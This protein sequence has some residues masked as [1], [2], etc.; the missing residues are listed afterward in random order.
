MIIK[1]KPVSQFPDF[2]TI[3]DELT[4]EFG[5]DLIDLLSNMIRNVY[6]DIVNLEKAAERVT[7]LPTATLDRRGKFVLVEGT[8][9]AADGLYLCADTGNGGYAFKTVAL[10]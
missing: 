2:Q 6:D 3:K 1:T 4:K 5:H 10:T 8:G 9:G 7:T